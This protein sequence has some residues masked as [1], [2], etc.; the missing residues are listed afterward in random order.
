MNVVC[1]DKVKKM[2]ARKGWT[3]E[4]LAYITGL[5][6]RTIQR[7]EKDGRCSLDS[8]MALSSAF[9]INFVELLAEETSLLDH[10]FEMR[11]VQDGAGNYTSLNISDPNILHVPQ[12]QIV[13]KNC[14]DILPPALSNQI[15]QAIDDLK[16]GAKSIEFDY[17]LAL[18]AGSQFFRAKIIQSG[19]DSFFSVVT[20]IGQPKASE[21]KLL[22]SEALLS[23]LADTLK[24]G[25]WEV[26]LATSETFWTQQVFDI[27]EIDTTPSITEG[28][29]FYAP[30]ARPIIQQAFENLSTSGE[31]YD[32]ELP[33]ITATGKKLWVRV[34]GWPVYHNDVIKKVSGVIQ[35]ITH[36]KTP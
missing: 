36:L 23:M 13:G 17:S 18:S 31:A 4:H 30:E 5:S 8:K 9:G 19:K 26:D 15:L 3:Q 7:I 33:F 6:N 24:S 25:A 20:E 2:R 34:S 10:F 32:L 14:A 11:F 35:D 28:I 27:Y 22:K 1:P 21:K 16:N 29:S 12:D